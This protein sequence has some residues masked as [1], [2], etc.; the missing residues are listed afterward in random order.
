MKIKEIAFTC[1]AVTDLRRA[2]HF[3][4]KILGL[5]ASSVFEKDNMGFIEYEIGNHTLAIGAGAPAFSPGK[6]GATVAFEV[7]DFDSFIKKLKNEK[8]SFVMD[9]HESPVCHMAIIVDPDG[10]Q[11]MIHKRKKK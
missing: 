11:M 4:E 6:T 9:S 8:V 10:N 2:R 7:D 5:T 1:Y 3:Y